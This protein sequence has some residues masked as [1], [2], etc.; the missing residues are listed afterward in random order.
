MDLQHIT[1]YIYMFFNLSCAWL[2]CLGD[3]QYSNAN[4]YRFSIIDVTFML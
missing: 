1:F 4:T 2:D 3:D